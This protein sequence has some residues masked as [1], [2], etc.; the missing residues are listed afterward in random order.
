MFVI[1]CQLTPFARVSLP[2]TLQL[3]FMCQGGDI[4]QG[5]GFGGESIFGER[6]E[7]RGVAG[8]YNGVCFLLNE[9]DRHTGVL[10]VA[11]SHSASC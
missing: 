8:G 9:F 6:F 4:T 5:N 1:L 10:M 11:V 3:Q 7:V 2:P